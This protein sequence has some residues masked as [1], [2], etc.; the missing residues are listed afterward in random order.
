VRREPA[1]AGLNAVLASTARLG[2]AFAALLSLPA[3]F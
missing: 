3:A 1:G 2:L